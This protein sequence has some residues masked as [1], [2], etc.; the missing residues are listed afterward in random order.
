MRIVV[1]SDVHIGYEH[2]DVAAFETFI[3][4][5]LSA[6]PDKVI[7][8]GD[9]FDFWRCSDVDLLVQNQNIVEKLMQL[10]L[11]YVCGNHDYSMLKLSRRFPQS[12]P[13]EV[14][15]S[16]TL[17]NQTSRFILRHGYELEVFTS[18]EPVGLESYEAFSEAMCHA[19]WIGGAIASWV[20]T[21]VELVRGRLT[22]AIRDLLMS[23]AKTPAEKRSRLQKVDVLAKSPSR[24]I[25][26]GLLP[27]DVLIF[28]HTH[29][30]FVDARTA[31]AGSWVMTKE[32][33]EHSYIEITDQSFEM[34]H[35]PASSQAVKASLKGKRPIAI[36]RQQLR[37]KRR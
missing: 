14:Q 22:D 35:W 3:D 23:A 29:R 2:S 36:R 13:F 25:L 18:M 27:S 37:R 20:W 34:K 12:P 17:Q 10:P 4:S 24:G 21:F 5:L 15:V 1:I 16:L 30:P 11:S 28:G 31:N 19:G 32:K 8:L 9:I 33:K 6:R 26:L 7:L